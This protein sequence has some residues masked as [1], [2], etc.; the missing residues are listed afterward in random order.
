M[1]EPTETQRI[2][3]MFE[4]WKKA[5]LV[6]TLVVALA[7]FVTAGFTQFMMFSSNYVAKED[8]LLHLESCADDW[9]RHRIEERE[10]KDDF[11]DDIAVLRDDIDKLDIK[12]D[13]VLLRL[14]PR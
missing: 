4:P 7:S 13:E 5:H 14:P 8:Y 9:S 6:I 1:P 12:L 11:K 2:K 10:D 3:A